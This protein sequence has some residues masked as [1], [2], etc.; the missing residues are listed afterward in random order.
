MDTTR[1]GWTN[2]AGRQG[3]SLDVLAS[4]RFT[5]QSSREAKPGSTA[6]AWNFSTS[7]PPSRSKKDYS[8]VV[9]VR[10]EDDAVRGG[11]SDI[12]G[13]ADELAQS[14]LSVE[15]FSTAGSRASAGVFDAKR[16][17]AELEK[18]LSY[19]E[20]G[21]RDL[22]DR[23]TE[24]MKEGRRGR[25]S[26]GDTDT[27]SM[28]SNSDHV[29][30]SARGD[31]SPRGRSAA[32]KESLEISALVTTIDE[33]RAEF[34][35]RLSALEAERKVAAGSGPAGEVSTTTMPPDLLAHV[36]TLVGASASLREEMQSEFKQSQCEL[37]ALRIE[38]N[39][40]RGRE[41]IDDTFHDEVEG[42]LDA[43]KRDFQTRASRA[44][45]KMMAQIQ[46]IKDLVKYDIEQSQLEMFRLQK[47]LMDRVM[48]LESE[49]F[50]DR[51]SVTERSSP[52]PK[53][54]YRTPPPV[55]SDNEGSS[56]SSG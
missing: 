22:N 9:S 37:Q 51:R 52:A 3:D 14:V 55:T 46:E 7:P 27:V 38:V 21:W 29:S 43:M 33:M 16:R 6:V 53:P 19:C 23:F 34:S 49:V 8:D 26:R 39:Q 20:A 54:R 48:M 35:L 2:W 44:D 18:R 56:S 5:G 50:G 17:V 4:G 30:A 13:G 11:Q 24:S 10:S 25:R 36:R 32:S 42:R 41:G 31:V 45:S 28:E 15:A 12:S 40:L 1:K 47:D